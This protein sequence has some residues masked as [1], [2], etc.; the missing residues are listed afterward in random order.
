M[1]LQELII[2]QIKREE[3][4]MREVAPFFSVSLNAA[5]K[6]EVEIQ[7]ERNLRFTFHSL[8]SA[9]DILN[10]IQSCPVEES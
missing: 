8:P 2:N 4:L 10:A 5:Y 3:L 9:A 1:E 7:G 6:W